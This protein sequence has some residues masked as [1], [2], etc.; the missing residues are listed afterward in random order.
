[1]LAFSISAN[2]LTFE[3]LK[4]VF[5]P[6]KTDEFLNQAKAIRKELDEEILKI[7]SLL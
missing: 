1:M 6:A 5:S 2:K 3:E 4:E 7:E